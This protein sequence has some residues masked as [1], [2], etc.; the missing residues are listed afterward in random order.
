MDPERN[1]VY[2]CYYGIEYEGEYIMRIFENERS[3]ELFVKNHPRGD[4][5]GV[6]TEEVH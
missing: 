5:Q 3:A 4:Y 1:F 6:W 2:I